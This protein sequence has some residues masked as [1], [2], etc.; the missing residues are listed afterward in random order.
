MS[1]TLLC[2]KRRV[3]HRVFDGWAVEEEVVAG[4]ALSLGVYLIMETNGAIATSVT[5]QEKHTR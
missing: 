3:N 2:E 5:H 1:Q 4:G